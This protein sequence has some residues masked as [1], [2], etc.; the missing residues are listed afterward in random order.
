[1]GRDVR[2]A[3]ARLAALVGAAVVIA[4]A[5]APRELTLSGCLLSNGYAGFLIEEATLHPID[6]TPADAQ[7]RSTA[8][9]KWVLD[10]GGNLRRNVGEKVRVVGKPEWSAE[11]KDDAPS[12]PHLEVSSVTTLAPACK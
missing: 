2:R 5:A 1:M 6:G 4:F 10:G 3:A 12:T 9:A 11:S 7:A 8:P